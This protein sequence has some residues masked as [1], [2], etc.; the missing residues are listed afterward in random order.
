MAGGALRPDQRAN[1]RPNTEA[2][3]PMTILDVNREKISRKSS[4]LT[5]RC[6]QIAP[7]SALGLTRV[8]AP[9]GP[10]RANWTFGA[11]WEG[12]VGGVQ[13]A[14]RCCWKRARERGNCTFGERVLLSPI[15]LVLSE[16]VFVLLL[17]LERMARKQRS[18]T[19][20][21][22]LSTSTSCHKHPERASWP[23]PGRRTDGARVV[24]VAVR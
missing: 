13:P 2:A 22:M 5:F 17:V 19:S 18:S 4:T 7:S 10:R 6:H 20:T 23:W 12:G 14:R 24:P 9:R 21:A 16:T 11:G 1:G 3:H 15:V 8:L